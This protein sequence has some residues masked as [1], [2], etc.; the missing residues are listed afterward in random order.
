MKSRDRRVLPTPAIINN[1]ALAGTLIESLGS[2]SRQ[3][4]G[5]GVGRGLGVGVARPP[6]VV[7]AVGVGVGL[8]PWQ[9]P[10]TLYT[11]CMSGK[12]ISAVGVGSFSP[13]STALR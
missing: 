9:V 13:Q 12:P 11:M 8:P 5:C 2:V 3:G 6:G 10:L 7:V 4:R 1:R